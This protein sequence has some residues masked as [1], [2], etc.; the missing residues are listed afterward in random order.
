MSVEADVLVVGAGPAGSATATHLARRGLDVALLEKSQF[1]REKVCG[2][3]L[4]P[5]ATR[6][7]IRLGIDTS[8]RRRLAAQQGPADLRRL[9]HAVRAALAG[10][11][12]LPV[13]R[14]WSARA[15]TSTTCWPATRWPRARS[16]T[17]CATSPPR[18]STTATGRIIGVTTKD[19]EELPRPAGRGRRRQLHPAEPGHGAG[20]AGR[21]A[22]GGGGPHL[23]PQPTPPRRP[24]GVLA[25]AVGGQAGAERSA[26]RLRLD[27][28]H[29]RRHLQRRASGCSTRPRR[30]ARPT[31]RTC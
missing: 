20:Q 18:S 5:R 19:G 23:L 2:D 3:G 1:P 17:S 26:A 22:D 12:R 6:Q 30:S 10:A 21:P 14:V 8:D 16:C 29:G 27:L 15:P 31:T 7:L 9:D 13:V 25:G 24:P 28:R 11:R 4:T